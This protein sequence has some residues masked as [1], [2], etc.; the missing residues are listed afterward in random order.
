MKW[1]GMV[2]HP[3]KMTM[4]S[5]LARL[6]TIQAVST[7]PLRWD[8]I[9]R[10]KPDRRDEATGYGA[11]PGPV[12]VAGRASWPGLASCSA[13]DELIALTPHGLDQVEA[14][15]GAQSPDARVDD[16]GAGVRVVAPDGGEQ[17]AL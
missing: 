14:E 1:N 8:S 13:S 17:P 7:R 6:K 12:P 11:A 9:H 3:G 2:S 4:K 16:V 5:R 15:L 10:D